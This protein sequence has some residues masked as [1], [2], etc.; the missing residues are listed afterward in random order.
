[1]FRWLRDLWERGAPKPP[2]PPEPPIRLDEPVPAEPPAP[3]PVRAA[4]RH[5]PAPEPAFDWRSYD[6]VAQE[7]ERAH[8][9]YTSR[10]VAD[11]LALSEA[12]P[13]DRVLDIG[14]G[15]A[16]ALETVGPVV[17][18][19]GLAVGVDP[20][21]EM[22]R[23]AGARRP[24]LRLAAAEALDLPFRDDT[25]DVALANFALPYFAKLDT[26]IYDIARVL[27]VGGRIA[28]S[29][30]GAGEDDLN[31]T[32][33]LLAQ[34]A[35]GVEVLRAGIRDEIPWAEK[36]SDP[37][38]L[39]AQLRDD[40]F[41]PVRVERRKYRFEISRED[42]V[43]GHEIEAIGRFVRR[44]LGPALWERFRERARATFAERFPEA[45]VDFRDVLLAVGT[46]PGRST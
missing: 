22:L 8:A 43:V 25:F 21:G 31:R 36:L 12:S 18:G 11:L 46:K 23:V 41:R 34:E 4:R 19:S 14:T 15:T 38:R 35:L 2:P 9:P 1:M 20:A 32:W 44:M 5:A 13:G 24:G 30:Y 7:Y 26:A 40:G 16:V 27:K 42:Y 10:P 6:D 39:E 3:E 37:A 17:G 45:L 28:V 33:R 29:V